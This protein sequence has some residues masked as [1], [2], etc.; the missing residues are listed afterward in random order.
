MC[1]MRSICHSMLVA[2]KADRVGSVQLDPPWLHSGIAN[3]V[4]QVHCIRYYTSC[5]QPSA[6]GRISSDRELQTDSSVRI[7]KYIADGCCFDSLVYRLAVT[8]IL[9]SA[10]TL[11]LLSHQFP[12]LHP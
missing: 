10:H 1:A 2:I 12:A 11:N 9:S 3:S 4:L 7:D 5:R 6:L 8:L